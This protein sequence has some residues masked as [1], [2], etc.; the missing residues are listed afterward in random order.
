MEGRRFLSGAT[1][2]V[3]R[4]RAL[5]CEYALE[6]PRSDRLHRDAGGSPLKSSPRVTIPGLRLPH[7]SYVATPSRSLPSPIWYFV[8]TLRL[9]MVRPISLEIG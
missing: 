1:F 6:T 3:F 4:G 5:L 2:C 9:A 8:S 7:V